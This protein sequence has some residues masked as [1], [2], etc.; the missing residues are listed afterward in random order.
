[1]QTGLKQ[2]NKSKIEFN[3]ALFWDVQFDSLD[4]ETHARFII[5][6]V[7]SRGNLADWNLLKKTYGKKRIQQE[8]LQIRSLDQKAVSFL[9]AYFGMEK[10]DSSVGYQEGDFPISMG[11]ISQKIFSLPMHPHLGANE[12]EY[13]GEKL[14]AMTV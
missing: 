14:K 6:R 4:I 12:I 7:V 9:S 2:L 1:M 5:E 11:R 10:T 3:K 13:I 8:A